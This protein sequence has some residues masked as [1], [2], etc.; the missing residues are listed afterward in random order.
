MRSLQDRSVRKAT[1]GASSRCWARWSAFVSAAFASMEGPPAQAVVDHCLLSPSRP[2]V[3]NFLYHVA[4]ELYPGASGRDQMRKHVGWLHRELI[5]RGGASPVKEHEGSRFNHEEICHALTATLKEKAEIA[6]AMASEAR[7]L[8]VEAGTAPDTAAVEAAGVR[9]AAPF[10]P[11]LVW[12]LLPSDWEK[13][14]TWSAAWRDLATVLLGSLAFLRAVELFR[15][16]PCDV[17]M[18]TLVTPASLRVAIPNDRVARTTAEQARNATRAVSVL[19]VGGP[20]CPVAFMA[21]WVQLAKRRN[22]EFLFHDLSAVPTLPIGATIPEASL[23]EWRTRLEAFEDMASKIMTAATKAIRD[24]LEKVQPRL[25]P[26]L[27]RLLADLR[28]Q[29]VPAPLSPRDAATAHGMRAGAATAACEAQMDLKQIMKLGRW[30]SET[31]AKG[32][33]QP[34]CEWAPDAAV[35]LNNYTARMLR[36]DQPELR[37]FWAARDA[38]PGLELPEEWHEAE[39]ARADP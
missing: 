10:R 38:K 39:R 21:A 24:R 23:K 31:S 17:H 37:A 26:I 3:I 7:R 16:R 35:R 34:R 5:D 6:G 22:K 15:L 36:A 28:I 32:Y 2:A 4:T 20:R 1:R 12:A 9:T 13:R 19:A 11:A 8:A 14:L 25:P 30:A 33:L 29:R 27:Q 18:D